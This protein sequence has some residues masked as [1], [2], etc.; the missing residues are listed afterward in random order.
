M[1][2]TS[3][4]EAKKLPLLTYGERANLVKESV[5]EPEQISSREMGGGSG[6]PKEEK[7]VTNH[8]LFTA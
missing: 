7:E 4:A 1:L 2:P 6:E 3:E 5:G 8:I